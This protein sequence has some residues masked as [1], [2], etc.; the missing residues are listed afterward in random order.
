MTHP[1]AVG[2]KQREKGMND[3][4]TDGMRTPSD[5]PLP[6]GESGVVFRDRHV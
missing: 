4:Q 3:T 2:F 6:Y 5:G 1:R